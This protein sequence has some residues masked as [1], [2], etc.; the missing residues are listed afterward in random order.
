M[1]PKK[2][3]TEVIV[4]T[5]FHDT[6]GKFLNALA[7]LWDEC[8]VTKTYRDE[9]FELYSKAD[10]SRKHIIKQWHK[11]MSPFY[12]DCKVQDAT[13]ILT[14]ELGLLDDVEFKEKYLDIVDVPE[15]LGAFWKY[16]NYLNRDASVYCSV[17]TNMMN[18]V[19][20]EAQELYTQI[21]NSGGI[22][23]AQFDLFKIGQKV[24]GNLNDKDISQ[25]VQNLPTMIE[26]LSNNTEMLDEIAPGVSSMLAGLANF[27]TTEANKPKHPPGYRKRK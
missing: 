14:A 23:N 22:E 24:A 13:N 18:V 6:L 17:S 10:I 4:L 2:K 11:T 16:I 26:G 8:K 19:Q 7:E 3:Q 21:M 1:P 27:G 15:S 25:M 20:N 9:Y 5:Q 12:G